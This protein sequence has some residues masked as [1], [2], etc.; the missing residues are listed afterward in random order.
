MNEFFCAGPSREVLYSWNRDAQKLVYTLMMM[1][2]SASLSR[3]PRSIDIWKEGRTRWKQWEIEYR[4]RFQ[5]LT[6][7]IEKWNVEI[8]F[9]GGNKRNTIVSTLIYRFEC[10]AIEQV[11]KR[12]RRERCDEW[13]DKQSETFLLQPSLRVSR[14]DR[15]I[16]LLFLFLHIHPRTLEC[17]RYI[18]RR[19]IPFDKC[20]EKVSHYFPYPSRDVDDDTRAFSLQRFEWVLFLRPINAPL[21]L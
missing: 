9:L 14:C 2:E 15:A 7:E 21:Y 5:L 11:R 10:R 20:N 13:Y 18:R 16:Y 6:Q 3:A 1:D 8:A 4:Q 12:Q 17:I 19:S